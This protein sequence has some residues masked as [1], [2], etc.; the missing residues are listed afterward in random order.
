MEQYRATYPGGCPSTSRV[1]EEQARAVYSYGCI[2]YGAVEDPVDALLMLQSTLTP[3]VFPDSCT[4]AHRFALESME[5]LLRS[6]HALACQFDSVVSCLTP[7]M[8]TYTSLCRYFVDIQKCRTRY[9]IAHYVCGIDQNCP[10]YDN[11]TAQ[12]WYA[13][14][15]CSPAPPLSGSTTKPKGGDDS[16]LPPLSHPGQSLP[17]TDT[18]S[19]STPPVSPISTH[20]SKPTPL[21]SQTSMGALAAPVNALL[22][23][24]CYATAVPPISLSPISF[25]TPVTLLGPSEEGYCPPAF[26][27]AGL[28]DSSAVSSPGCPLPSLFS[29]A[30]PVPSVSLSS[31]LLSATGTPLLTLPENP[32][33]ESGNSSSIAIGSTSLHGS[34]AATSLSVP[35]VSFSTSPFTPTGTHLVPL[36]VNPIAVS[37][38]VSSAAFGDTTHPSSIADTSPD[39]TL[40]PVSS[41]SRP[42]P[43]VSVSSSPFATP[44]PAPVSHPVNSVGGGGDCGTSAEGSTDQPI[45]ALPV[46]PTPENILGSAVGSSRV[47]PAVK[48]PSTC[49]S[50]SSSSVSKLGRGSRGKDKPAKWKNRK[51]GTHALMSSVFQQ[52]KDFFSDDALPANCLKLPVLVDT[53]TRSKQEKYIFQCLDALQRHLAEK[54][55]S[56]NRLYNFPHVVFRYGNLR[57][58][59]ALHASGTVDSPVSLDSSV[60]S[61]IPPQIPSAAAVWP[62]SGSSFPTPSYPP[63]P[64]STERI[65]YLLAERVNY[66]LREPYDR[67]SIVSAPLKR[68]TPFNVEGESPCRT[69]FTPGDLFEGFELD[70]TLENGCLVF[71]TLSQTVKP[72]SHNKLNHETLFERVVI[73]CLMEDYFEPEVQPRAKDQF[74]KLIKVIRD[75]TEINP[76]ILLRGI[77]HTQ[78]D[79]NEQALNAAILGI[80]S[81]GGIV[82]LDILAYL[83][84]DVLRFT[85]SIVTYYLMGK[86]YRPNR[87]P[88]QGPKTPSANAYWKASIALR[89]SLLP[90]SAN[91]AFAVPHTQETTGNPREELPEMVHI[92]NT[93]FPENAAIRNKQEAAALMFK[94]SNLLM[95]YGCMQYEVFDCDLH[96][97]VSGKYVQQGGT[98]QYTPEITVRKGGRSG[99]EILLE[100][101][102]PANSHLFPKLT[103]HAAARGW[104]ADPTS[105]KVAGGSKS[106]NGS[107]S[108]EIIPPSTPAR[109]VLAEAGIEMALSQTPGSIT[110]DSVSN[111]LQE[112]SNEAMDRVRSHRGYK[113]KS[114]WTHIVPPSTP[115]PV[116]QDEESIETIN[117]FVE[118]HLPPPA[119]AKGGKRNSRAR[120]SSKNGRKGYRALKKCTVQLEKLRDIPSSSNTSSSLPTQSHDIESTFRTEHPAPPC[121]SAGPDSDPVLAG[122]SALSTAESHSN[123]R[124]KLLSGENAK[125]K[126]TH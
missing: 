57:S 50:S 22:P 104:A 47:V 115:H 46:T 62:E 54:I 45:S 105:D 7:D 31:S 34:N 80:V 99:T 75:I 10:A 13:S 94:Y 29:S 33:D 122:V 85:A 84:V 76:P 56:G 117:L 65:Q 9:C 109:T 66:C 1:L 86:K 121:S 81:G 69:K 51:K 12:K 67:E 106:R 107:R 53:A 100:E 77:H 38:N 58:G 74:T 87:I 40:T 71:D 90:E 97:G 93:Y 59:A 124:G 49:S 25:S 20:S 95:T 78:L 92:G 120:K 18:G 73:S 63:L 6:Y 36:P 8:S 60:H 125:K 3:D 16:V 43:S 27:N 37:G 35:S 14:P 96:I 28:T 44:G 119:Q 123:K 82:T 41:A 19:I 83:G 102:F 5:K 68:T 39:C 48:P 55:P 26:G 126:K 98:L 72:K 17:H 113:S 70:Y 88:F 110:A 30:P 91:C 111:Q 2:L 15:T 42:V 89:N 61:M 4:T 108:R 32:T 23:L 103:I 116:M 52:M 21:P 118:E 101:I 114:K 24:P 79:V 11:M 64:R 112:G